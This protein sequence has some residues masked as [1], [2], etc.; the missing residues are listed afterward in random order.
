MDRAAAERLDAEDPLGPLRGR[1]TLP[2][3][4][5]YLDG[6][7]LGPAQPAV[8]EAVGTAL[9]RDW[10]EGLIRSWNA[11]VEG[12]G[13][14]GLP[15]RVAGA[16]AP[17][18]GADADEVAV[19]DSTSVDLYAVLVALARLRP[20]RR[21]ILLQEGDFPTD[22][23]VA[24]SVADLLGLEVR[25]APRDRLGEAIDDDLA[26]LV[27]TEVDYRT[28]SRH[29]APDLTR[30]VHSAGG[31]VL[32]DLSHSAGALDVDLHRWDA[33]AAVGCT[34][35]FLNGGPGA[36]AYLYV[37]RRLHARI[38]PTVAGWFGHATPFSFADEYVPAPD[39]SRFLAGTP[40]VLSMVALE[41]ALRIQAD[42]PADA[43]SA[44]VASL[45]EL[46]ID[47]VDRHCDGFG[48]E[49]VTPRS[50]AARGAQVSLRHAEAGR[51]MRAL[52]DRGV[53]GDHRPP[54]IL[55]FGFSPLF[56]RHTD[57]WDAVHVLVEVLSS[58][59][60]RDDRYDRAAEVP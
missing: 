59:A 55:R 56:V 3:R 33:D 52:V 6:N 17:L 29:D 7:S 16:I 24:G 51:V 47:L 34:Y 25:T 11:T 9:H 23:Y 14:V 27:L 49:V 22:R 46:F 2:D 21:T 38:R 60:W 43:R 20:E 39:A 40:P 5:I 18:V 58:G 54:D 42:V 37:A 12:P 32:W 44:K 36:P 28:G 1:F 26:V 41:A 15:R 13:W 8:A 50:P 30:T 48:L 10:S 19:T 31:L 4:V 57:V 53:I 45:T 35:K